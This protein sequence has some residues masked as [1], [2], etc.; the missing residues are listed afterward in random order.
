[1]EEIIIHRVKQFE[2]GYL[3]DL[4]V[5]VDG[6]KIAL[7]KS[8]ETQKICV[9]PGVHSVHVEQGHSV[10]NS[11][12]VDTRYSESSEI[13]VGTWLCGWKTMFTLFFILTM[14]NLYYARLVVAPKENVE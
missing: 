12:V 5:F 1:M 7:I 9:K 8:G 13:E 2:L 10:S 11:V 6:N 14:G 3:F 4:E